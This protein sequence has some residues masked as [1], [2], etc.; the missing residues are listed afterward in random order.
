MCFLLHFIHIGDIFSSLFLFCYILEEISS[1]ILS[2]NFVQNI[3]RLGMGLVFY[4]ITWSHTTTSRTWTMSPAWWSWP[5]S[6]SSENLSDHSAWIYLLL[7]LELL[8]GAAI[9]FCTEASKP[10]ATKPCERYAPLAA[11]FYSQQW[12]MPGPTR[13]LTSLCLDEFL[14]AARPSSLY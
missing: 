2:Q 12:W 1:P 13:S 7:T 4:Y 5:H 9:T 3:T 6:L 10:T 14:L 11:S 8:K